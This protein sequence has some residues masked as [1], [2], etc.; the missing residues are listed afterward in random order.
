MEL[1]TVDL[2]KSHRIAFAG[3]T[4][5]GSIAFHSKG[6][7]TLLERVRKEKDLYL[8]LMGDLLECILIDDKRFEIEIHGLGK[9]FMQQLHQLKEELMPVRKKIITSH[10]GNHEAKLFKLGDFMR[11]L[12]HELTVP[13]G[14]YSAKT[15]VRDKTG[16]PLY[17]IFST[18]GRLT[19]NSTADDPVRRRSNMQLS[20]KRRLQHLAGDCS[21]MC[22][23]HS[24]KLLVVPPE[25]ELYITDDGVQLQAKY[26]RIVQQGDY[27]DPSLRYYGSS[28][29]FL[30]SAVIGATTYS[31][32]AGYAPAVLGY[33]ELVVRDGIVQNIKEIHLGSDHYPNIEICE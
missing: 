24:H 30:K 26:T 20:L 25:R 14:G 15:T 11:D 3:D 12:C 1:V 28:G 32:A 9:F 21:I 4:H 5:Q 2:P 22:A 13:Y 33:L 8:L 16:T 29:S 7:K 23:G 6:W 17:K 19:V 31:E 18:H 10:F 27:I